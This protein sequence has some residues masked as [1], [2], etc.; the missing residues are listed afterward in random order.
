MLFNTFLLWYSKELIVTT[1]AR[2][3]EHYILLNTF[4]T[5]Y[6]NYWHVSQIIVTYCSL[7]VLSTLLGK[8]CCLQ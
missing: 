5:F 4:T 7:W 3:V 6:N 1:T 8:K 2:G